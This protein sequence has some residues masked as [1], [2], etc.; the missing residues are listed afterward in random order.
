MSHSSFGRQGPEVRILSPRPQFPPF[1]GL[2][3][4]SDLQNFA[5]TC[6]S[7][8]GTRVQIPYSR[9]VTRLSTPEGER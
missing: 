9:I 4:K 6:A 1:L 3:P 8:S 5:G 7:E 2:A